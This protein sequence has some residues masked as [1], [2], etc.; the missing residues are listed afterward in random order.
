MLSK[1]V[2]GGLTVFIV[3]DSIGKTAETVINAVASQFNANNIKLKKFTNVTSI[4]KLSEI[5]NRAEKNNVI[6]AYTIVLPELCEYIEDVAKKL[7]IEI[8]D[9][10]G[11]TMSKFSEVLGQKPHLEPGLNRKIDQAYF[12]RIACIDFAVRCDDGKDLRRLK[13]AD[14]VVTGV[15]R[16]SKTPL[17]MYLAHQGYKAANIP[18][19]PEVDPP[20]E[21]FDLPSYKVV[22]LTI[23]PITLQEIRKQ[24]LKAMQFN[25]NADY[26]KVNRILDEL[27][28]AEKI[29]K[30]IGCMIINVTNK[31]IEET[32]SKILSERGEL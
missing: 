2:N 9:I 28:F 30:K 24:R 1:A 32:A 12:E 17:S 25:K 7:S 20:Q 26:A 21:L 27:D 29:M 22:G 8:I 10:M 16:T 4:A 6:L 15:S 3:S 13:E 31:S 19:V 23:D 14:I 18:I 5:I 11:P